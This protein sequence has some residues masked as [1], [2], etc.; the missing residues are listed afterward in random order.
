VRHASLRSLGSLVYG[1][2][3]ERGRAQPR[4]VTTQTSGSVVWCI[5]HTAKRGARFASSEAPTRWVLAILRAAIQKRQTAPWYGTP[6][7]S[8]G[9]STA[10]L[11]Q[12][13]AHRAQR[14]P[15][16]RRRRRPSFSRRRVRLAVFDCGGWRQGE[17]MGRRAKPREGEGGKP[18][19]RSSVSIEEEAERPRT[20]ATPGGEPGAGRPDERSRI[21]R[22]TEQQTATSESAGHQSVADGMR[23]LC[24]RRSCVNAVRLCGALHGGVYRL[25]AV[26]SPA[27]KK[28]KGRP[29]AALCRKS[30]AAR[31]PNLVRVTS[32]KGRRSP[33]R[34]S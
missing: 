30:R 2:C 9:D 3:G 31:R 25:E 6:C 19:N 34:S 12:T 5:T 32:G 26:S 7:T 4:V 22:V 10:R 29:R 15:R 33:S 24:S 20:R 16:R 14:R 28:R 17:R 23:S 27:D 11:H 8:V 21:D 18:S 13:H 1:P